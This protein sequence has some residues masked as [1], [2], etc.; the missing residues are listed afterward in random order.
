MEEKA[1]PALVARKLAG[2]FHWSLH[3][4]EAALQKLPLAF[5]R[6][7]D[8]VEVN[9]MVFAY[10][11]LGC[12]LQVEDRGAAKFETA[13][14]AAPEKL[15]M[16]PLPEGRQGDRP[17]E[18]PVKRRRL[19][20]NTRDFRNAALLLSLIG[21]LAGGIGF[22]KLGRKR[23]DLFPLPAAA[24]ALAPAEEKS[25]LNDIRKSENVDERIENLLRALQAHPGN[26]AFQEEL[27]GNYTEKGIRDPEMERRIRFFKLAL[28]FNKKNLDAWYG[29]ISTYRQSGNSD[30]ADMAKRKMDEIIK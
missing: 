26:P 24:P 10:Q 4:A 12:R 30:S 8:S 18:P 9:A 23:P 6:L 28:S 20:L 25:L 7:L 17:P 5:P 19:A 16:P 13:R 22:W 1:N 11:R 14:E 2:D 3:Q 29:L 21:I 27:S 15:T